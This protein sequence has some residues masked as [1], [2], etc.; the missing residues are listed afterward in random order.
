M[1]RKKI[2]EIRHC[3]GLEHLC[4][5]ITIYLP[6]CALY[7][8]SY[9]SISTYIVSLCGVAGG[10]ICGG[11]CSVGGGGGVVGGGGGAVAVAHGSAV[12]V[13]DDVR[14]EQGVSVQ[15]DHR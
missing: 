10:S 12:P 9:L 4:C 7:T 6:K 5:Q 13:R 1:A 15:E 3:E 2:P 8:F 14:A 11:G